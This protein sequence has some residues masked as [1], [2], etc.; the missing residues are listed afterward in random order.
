M[1]AMFLEDLKHS[2]EIVLSERKRVHATNHPE[3][4][5]R[6]RSRKYKRGS[7]SRAAIG[8]LGIGSAVTAA[9]TNRRILG[10]AE[11]R[12]MV[13]AS[14][15]LAVLSVVAVL[16][17]RVVTIPLAVLGV[18]IAIALVIR[19]YRLHNEGPSAEQKSPQARS[20]L[21]QSGPL[22]AAPARESSRADSVND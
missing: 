6:R 1:E 5:R 22:P 18:W 9:I 15:M 7:A 12:V 21:S 3:P 11:A 13:A 17:P 14:C 4:P 10:P 19:A 20:I 8:A 2:T 16:W